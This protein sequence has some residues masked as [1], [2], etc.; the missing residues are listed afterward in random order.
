[1]EAVVDHELIAELEAILGQQEDPDGFHS[2]SDLCRMLGKGADSVRK[3]LKVLKRAGRLEERYLMK[4][5]ELGPGATKKLCYRV[6]PA[7]NGAHP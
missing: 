4:P 7:T 6:L 2:T 1:M 3:R 5:N